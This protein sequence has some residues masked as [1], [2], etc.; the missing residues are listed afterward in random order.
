M[1]LV[2]ETY[3]DEVLGELRRTGYDVHHV[4]LLAPREV[5][6]ERLRRRGLGRG[7][8]SDLRDRAMSGVE[9]AGVSHWIAWTGGSPDHSEYR[10]AD[11]SLAPSYDD[12]P[13]AHSPRLTCPPCCCPH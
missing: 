1:T 11:A 7:L 5:V 6:I 8:V 2:K 4:A 10:W 3:F 12:E 13:A 9:V